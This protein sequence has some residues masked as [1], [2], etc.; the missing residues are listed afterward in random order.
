MS[1]QK[2]SEAEDAV[3]ER[4]RPAGCVDRRDADVGGEESELQSATGHFYRIAVRLST[5]CRSHYGAA[6]TDQQTRHF[7]AA[8]RHAE[9]R[10]AQ[11]AIGIFPPLIILLSGS[12][13][14]SFVDVLPVERNEQAAGVPALGRA[15]DYQRAAN[16]GVHEALAGLQHA[17]RRGQANTAESERYRCS[18]CN[19]FT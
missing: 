1:H 16:R 3:V 2:R 15:D 18:I 8:V 13:W 6:G 10:G 14:N 4:H 19:T 12:Q 17:E 11:Q 7:S 5:Q 9:R